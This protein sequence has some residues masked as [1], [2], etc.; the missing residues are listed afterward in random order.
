MLENLQ[1]DDNVGF[2]VNYVG[3][4]A[5]NG[6]TTYIE[7]EYVNQETGERI[8]ADTRGQVIPYCTSVTAGEPGRYDFTSYVRA[9]IVDTEEA[10]RTSDWLRVNN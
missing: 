9:R 6:E 7:F 4:E 10:Q 2:K 1:M 5:L 8:T 3:L